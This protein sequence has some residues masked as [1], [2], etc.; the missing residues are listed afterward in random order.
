[1]TQV[2]T[3]HVVAGYKLAADIT[4][5]LQVETLEKEK[6]TF[7]TEGKNVTI[8]NDSATV[9]IPNV[10]ATNGVVH[11]IDEVLIPEDFKNPCSSDFEAE[12][13]IVV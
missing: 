10:F 12:G 5:G 4:D 7:A 13:A 8:N 2:L 11:V 9:V 1:M 6:L 3:Y